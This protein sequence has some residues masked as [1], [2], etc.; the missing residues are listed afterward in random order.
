[1]TIRSLSA[2]ISLIAAILLVLV[3]CKTT[4][5]FQIKQIPQPPPTAKV[6]IFVLMIS[7]F[8]GSYWT[9]PHKEWAKIYGEILAKD[10]RETDIYNVIPH[11][12]I[13]RVI[14]EEPSCWGGNASVLGNWMAADE[15]VTGKLSLLGN[16]LVLQLKMIN[17]HTVETLAL[18]SIHGAVGKEVELIRGMPAL[19][20][21]LIEGRK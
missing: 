16:T 8:V 4:A 14:S 7:G 13:Y 1:M 21:K 20:K 10:Y 3:S 18:S 12:D 2:K 6:R 11:E 17:I 5:D 15:A 9:I 19:V